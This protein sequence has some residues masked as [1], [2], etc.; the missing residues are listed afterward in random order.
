LKP[1]LVGFDATTLIGQISGVGGYTARLLQALSA[2]AGRG[3]LGKVVV[4]S[5]RQIQFAGPPQVEIYDGRRFPVRSIWM[6]L[7]LPGILRD[8]RPEVVH[9]TN[10]LAPVLTDAPYVVSFHDMSLTLLPEAHT[11]K[12][13]LLTASLI[14]TVARRARRILVPSEST[15]RDVTRLLAVDPGRIRL[16]PYAA[17]PLYRPLSD[18]PRA[19]ARRGVRPPYFLYVGTI[20]PRKNLARA[21]RAFGRIV[22]SLPDHSFVIVGQAGWKYGEVLNEARRSDLAQKVVL[23][24]YLPEEELPLLYNHAVA[25]VYPSLYEGFGLPLVEAMACGTPVL[26]SSG[27]SLSEVAADAALLVPPLSEEKLAEAMTAL[28]ADEGLRA[29]LRRRGFERAA[30]FSWERTARETIEVYREVAQEGAGRA[31]SAG[32]LDSLT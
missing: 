31:W 10:Y 4:L 14:P 30:R 2:E 29:D 7:V 15:R 5:N 11:L 28:A 6:Q 24:G 27:S 12:K 8:L 1:I 17:S 25:L 13:R 16:V 3:E 21:L 32:R 18:G 22:P 26:T 23:T 9:F 20:E 19:L